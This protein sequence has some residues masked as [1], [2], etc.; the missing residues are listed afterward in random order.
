MKLTTE[1]IRSITLGT[2]N[3]YEENG[4]TV[5][6]RFTR[7][8]DEVLAGRNFTPRQFSTAGVKLEFISKKGEVFLE[9]LAQPGAGAVCHGI[10]ALC[11]GVE[12]FHYYNTTNNQKGNVFFTVPYDGCKVTVYLANMCAIRIKNLNVPEGYTPVK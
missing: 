3:V 8:Q 1:Q 2:L 11:D 7:Y 4:Y 10:D 12:A 5:F 6:R 9:Y